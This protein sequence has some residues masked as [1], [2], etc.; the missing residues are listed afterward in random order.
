MLVSFKD[1]TKENL[2]SHQA[3]INLTAPVQDGKIKGT[4]FLGCNKTI[5]TAA[6]KKSGTVT[7]S[8]IGSTQAACQ[9]M[10]F[11]DEFFISFKKMHRYLIEG[12]FLILRDRQGNS[13]QFIASDW[14]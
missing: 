1:Y 8:D 6:F 7:F 3:K 11:E 13:M 12:H 10:E 14:D 9:E 2:I 5:F 4:A